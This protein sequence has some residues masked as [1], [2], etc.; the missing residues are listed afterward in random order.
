MEAITLAGPVA[1]TVHLNGTL[2]A[3]LVAP[4]QEAV[5]AISRAIQ[6]LSANAPHGRDYYVQR[7]DRYA[8]AR[9]QHAQRLVA[10][11][12]VANELLVVAAAIEIQGKGR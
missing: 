8:E 9:H 10:L 12:A 5:E 1:P 6:V 11:Q 4:L 2:K 7:P 3:D